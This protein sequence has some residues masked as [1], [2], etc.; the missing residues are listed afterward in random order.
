[1]AP[2]DLSRLGTVAFPKRCD[3]VDLMLSALLPEVM[4][5][6]RVETLVDRKVRQ[7]LRHEADEEPK[8]RVASEIRQPGVEP[9]RGDM[10][11]TFL[12]GVGGRLGIVRP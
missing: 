1:M 9:E 4:V 12:F 5:W 8:K 10:L 2:H 11:A 3:Q 7:D 6:G